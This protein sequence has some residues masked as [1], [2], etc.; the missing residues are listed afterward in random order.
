MFI[1]EC[2]CFLIVFEINECCFLAIYFV[3][4][5]F[6]KVKFVLVEVGVNVVSSAGFFLVHK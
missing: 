4:F 5:I 2:F 1:D 3:Q 6:S